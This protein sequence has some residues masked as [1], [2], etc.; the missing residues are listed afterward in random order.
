[1]ILALR[2]DNPQA[3][4]YVCSP[5]KKQI[6]DVVWHAHRS[7]SKE[8][9]HKIEELFDG[10]DIGYPDLSGVIFYKGP[11]SFTGLRIGASVANT[12]A[13]EL[14]IPIVGSSGND[15]LEQGFAL[16]RQ[17]TKNRIVLPDYGA[18]PRTTKP[19]K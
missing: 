14:D 16:L 12:L 18:E 1:M 11:G 5:D 4:I 3:E 9:H 8:I 6:A 19:K 7:L 2:T 10:A 13:G 15:W 17:D